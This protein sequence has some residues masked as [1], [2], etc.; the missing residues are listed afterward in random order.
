MMI[1]VVAAARDPHRQAEALRGPHA[2]VLAA[3]PHPM[4]SR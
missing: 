3:V 2:D 4:S 1:L